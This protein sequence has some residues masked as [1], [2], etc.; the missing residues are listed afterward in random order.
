MSRELSAQGYQLVRHTVVDDEAEAIEVALKSAFENAD[1]VITTGGIG[2]T[3]DDRTRVSIG[4]VMDSKLELNQKVLQDLRSRFGDKLQSLEDQ[5]TI[6]LKAVPLLNPVGTAPGLLFDQN[7]KVLCVLPG[8]PYEMESLF[9][10]QFVPWLNSK[11]KE[12]ITPHVSTVNFIGIPENT[13]DYVLRQLEQKYP[14]IQFG[15]YPNHWIVVVRMSSKNRNAVEKATQEL[16]QAFRSNTFESEQSLITDAVHRLFRER[17]LTLACAES[18]T[19]GAI[20]AGLTEQ[21]GASDFFLGSIVSYSNEMKQKLL[22]VS[23][24]TLQKYGAVSEECLREMLHGLLKQV[25]SDWGVAVT[26]IAGPS[27]GTS[28]KPVGT[29]WCA[30]GKRNEKP[31]I[32]KLQLR[33][34]RLTNIRQTVHLV[35]GKLYLAIAKGL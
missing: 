4:K 28:E 25:G 35:L 12:L 7:G 1:I 13:V 19:G 30:I 26:G 23:E 16:K 33:A 15:I 31:E 18:C 3:I 11:S 10:K 32:W 17:K 21:S 9:A 29:I 20:A 14:D 22:G 27:G 8:V 5:A 34:D 2:P 6:P 24:E